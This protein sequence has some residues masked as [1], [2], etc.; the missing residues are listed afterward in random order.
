MNSLNCSLLVHTFDAYSHLWQGFIESFDQ[1]MLLPLNMPLYWGTN[2]L[3]DTTNV[4]PSRWNILYSGHGAWSDR[5][6]NLVKQIPTDYIFYMQEDHWPFGCP[7]EI[8]YMYIHNFMAGKE[9]LRVQFSPINRY[10]QLQGGVKNFGVHNIP[11]LY[12]HNDSKYLVSHQPSMWKK[13][14]LLECLQSGEDPW[15][16]EYKGSLRLKG[17]ADLINK[18]GIIPLNWFDHVCVKGKFIEPL[19]GK[20]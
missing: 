10:Y 2:I 11:I 3:S 8:E 13:S 14:F 12:F 1:S 7:E 9:I 17:R 20:I 6:I 15:Q 16:N 19:K 5:L 4:I 18:I